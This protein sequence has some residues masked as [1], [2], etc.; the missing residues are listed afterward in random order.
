MPKLVS[1]DIRW[2][3]S[4]V[5]ALREGLHLEPKSEEYISLIE[6]DFDEYLRQRYDVSKPYINPDGSSSTRVPH[7]DFWLVE[8]DRF[9]GMINVRHHLND[10]LLKFGGHIGYAVRASERRKGY[11]ALMLQL[12]LPKVKALGLDKVLL[13]CNDDNEGSA[14]IIEGAGGVLENVVDMPGA[15]AKRRYWIN[16]ASAPVAGKRPAG[17]SQGR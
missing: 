4:Y 12:A 6:T 14:R 2:R 9:L 17:P 10:N 5:E 7:S 1:P 15:P 8:G 13:T 3:D 16:L 11:G